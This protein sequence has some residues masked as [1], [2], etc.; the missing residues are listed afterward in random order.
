VERYEWAVYGGSQTEEVITHKSLP[1]LPRSKVVCMQVKE[2]LN[3]EIIN[4]YM[5]LAQ[6]SGGFGTGWGVGPDGER[7]AK[8]RSLPG[9]G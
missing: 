1:P 4:M 3:D 6:A 8:K 9:F 5:T 7:V 2:W